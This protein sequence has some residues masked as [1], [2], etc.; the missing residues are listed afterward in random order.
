[1]VLMLPAQGPHWEDYCSGEPLCPWG[2]ANGSR[3]LTV[4]ALALEILAAVP[5]LWAARIAVAC[6]VSVEGLMA[7][8]PAGIGG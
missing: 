5:K 8:A 7:A 6:V 2:Q 1:M 3:R 4:A